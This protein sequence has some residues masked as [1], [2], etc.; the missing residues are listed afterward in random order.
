MQ[1][2]TQSGEQWVFRT[3]GGSIYDGWDCPEC[4]VETMFHSN[5]KARFCPLCFDG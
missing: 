3:P 2:Y 4:H 1:I 5:L